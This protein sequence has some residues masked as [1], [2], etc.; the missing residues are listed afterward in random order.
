M[1]N[2]DRM[3]DFVLGYLC[4]QLCK[5]LCHSSQL[6]NDFLLQRHRFSPVM[7]HVGFVVGSVALEDVFLQALKISIASYLCGTAPY[8]SLIWD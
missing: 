5:V 4:M 1:D 7:V 2:G 8:C 3:I 6:V